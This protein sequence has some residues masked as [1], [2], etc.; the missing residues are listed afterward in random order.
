MAFE[1]LDEVKNNLKDYIDLDGIDNS[2]PSFLFFHL[3]FIY[4]VCYNKS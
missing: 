1:T 2:L 3:T 4:P